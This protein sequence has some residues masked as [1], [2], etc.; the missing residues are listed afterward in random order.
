MIAGTTGEYCGGDGRGREGT[1]GDDRRGL[2]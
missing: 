2:A 1:G